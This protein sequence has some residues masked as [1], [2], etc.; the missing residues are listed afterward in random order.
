M[1]RRPME[2]VTWDDIPQEPVRK[3][4]RRRG[5][6][7][8]DCLL[9]MNECDPGMDLR[10]HSHDFDQI[11]MVTKGEAIYHV[12]EVANRM[13]PGSMVIIPAGT[14]HYIEPI[15]DET[16]HNLDVFAPLRG[17]LAHLLDWMQGGEGGAGDA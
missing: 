6:G 8:E 2:A 4:V 16:V 12:G 17:D 3:G 10:P 1:G 5:F 15:G 13:G 14:E 9:V 7:N 11:A